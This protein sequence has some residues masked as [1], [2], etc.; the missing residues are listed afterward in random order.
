MY[1]TLIACALFASVDSHSAGYVLPRS[2]DNDKPP[3][4]SWHLHVVFDLD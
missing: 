2:Q 4:I 1:K 3:A